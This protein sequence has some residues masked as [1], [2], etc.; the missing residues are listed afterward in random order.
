VDLFA[1]LPISITAAITKTTTTVATIMSAVFDLF[2]LGVCCG[3]FVMFNPGE[4]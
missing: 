3:M 4:V 1:V 2:D